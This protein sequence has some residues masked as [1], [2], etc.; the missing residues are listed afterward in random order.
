MQ[1]QKDAKDRKNEILDAAGELF[2]KKGFDGTSTNDILETVGIARGT[3]YH[4]FKSKEDILD[5]IIDRY[6]SEI[7]V[8]LKETANDKSI[9]VTERLIGSIMALKI[10]DK[11]SEGIKNEIHKPQNA[12]MS[13]KVQK[14]IINEVV[15]IFAHIAEDGVK[16][17]IFSTPFPYEAIEMLLVYANIIFDDEMAEEEKAMS[18]IQGFLFNAERLL[19]AKSG[20]IMLQNALR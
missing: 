13:Q 20:S 10:R 1:V 19:G 6:I 9:P 2:A 11:N 8:R 16:E 3:L 15:P 7:L 14:V 12:L 17:G 5:A 18:R 4:H